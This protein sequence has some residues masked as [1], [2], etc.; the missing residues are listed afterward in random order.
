MESGIS[1]ILD[2]AEVLKIQTKTPRPTYR[3]YVPQTPGEEESKS[4]H[5]ARMFEQSLDIKEWERHES[6][7]SKKEEQLQID[8]EKRIS[9][10]FK[11]TDNK[12]NDSIDDFIKSE[13]YS[14]HRPSLP[15]N[16]P[17][18]RQRHLHERWTC[19][20]LHTHIRY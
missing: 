4:A 20:L 16:Q 11:I 15:C 18:L 2:E 14:T 7:R 5:E 8:A 9:I 17:H 6:I 10:L 19:R 1:Y 13:L 3:P 12:I